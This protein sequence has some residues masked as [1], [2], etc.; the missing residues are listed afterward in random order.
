MI[1][2]NLKHYVYNMLFNLKQFMSIFQRDSVSQTNYVI[3]LEVN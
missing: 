3:T 1:V 2:L